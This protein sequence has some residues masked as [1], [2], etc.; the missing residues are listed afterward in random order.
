M[1]L[2]ILLVLATCAGLFAYMQHDMTKRRA[3]LEQLARDIGGVANEDEARAILHGV[4]VRFAFVQR[5][6]GK[7]RHWWT[8]AECTPPPAYPLDLHVRRHGWF[9]ERMIACGTMVDVQVGDPRF[10]ETFL[11]EAAPADVVRQLFDQDFRTF[12]LSVSG[13]LTSVH[14]GPSRVVRLSVRGRIED[15][16][17]ARRYLEMLAQLAARVPA[18]FTQADAAIPT[19]FIGSPFREIVDTSAQRDAGGQRLIEVDRVAAL[20]KARAKQT[21]IVA[22]IVAFVL[23][24]SYAVYAWY[25]GW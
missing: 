25:S 14:E 21:R 18:A 16:G 24:G 22:I 3:M 23:C 12:L 4:P 2:A 13:A 19:R 1:D 7:S 8:E 9:D 20:R 11:V 6:S 5:G 15:L 10:D 17:E